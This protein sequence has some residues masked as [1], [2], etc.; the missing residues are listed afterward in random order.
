MTTEEDPF[1]KRD[2]ELKFEELLQSCLRQLKDVFI[3][4]KEL[5]KSEEEALGKEKLRLVEMSLGTCYMIYAKLDDKY[6]EIADNWFSKVIEGIISYHKKLKNLPYYNG[7][8]QL[9]AE[10]L[11]SC[12]HN[13]GLNSARCGEYELARK[14]YAKQIGILRNFYQLLGDKENYYEMSFE[15]GISIATSFLD[16]KKFKEAQDQIYSCKIIAEKIKKNKKNFEIIEEFKN[17]L[18]ED[19]T[20]YLQLLKIFDAHKTSEKFFNME[21]IEMESMFLKILKCS[22]EMDFLR[23]LKKIG[24]FEEK[25][26]LLLA[27]SILYKEGDVKELKIELV[28]YLIDILRENKSSKPEAKLVF[29][30][31]FKYWRSNRVGNEEKELE[32]LISCQCDYISILADLKISLEEIEKKVEELLESIKQS[33]DLQN[34]IFLL[35]NLEAIY[36]E[37]NV[38]N[39]R[40]DTVS[41]QIDVLKNTLKPN[42]IRIDFKSFMPFE[43]PATKKKSQADSIGK[44]KFEEEKLI[45]DMVDSSKKK[46]R[47]YIEE[48]KSSTG[49]NSFTNNQESFDQNSFKNKKSNFASS[50]SQVRPK[51]SLASACNR[52]EAQKENEATFPTNTKKKRRI[53]EFKNS[54]KKNFNRESVIY[55]SS[56]FAARKL[57]QKS[58]IDIS[59]D[60]NDLSIPEIY[61][62]LN[63]IELFTKFDISQQEITDK[64]FKDLIKIVLKIL[65]KTIDSII[66][67][68]RVFLI[69]ENFLSDNSIKILNNSIILSGLLE[70]LTEFDISWNSFS[71]SHDLISILEH[72]LLRNNSTLKNFGICGL[73]ARKEFLEDEKLQSRFSNLYMDIFAK[74]GQLC[75]LSLSKIGLT[76]FVKDFKEIKCKKLRM[77][78]LSYNNFNSGVIINCLLSRFLL[79]D[80]FELDL[81]YQTF[82]AEIAPEESIL[83]DLDIEAEKPE[84]KRL[85]LLSL[86]CISEEILKPLCLDSKSKLLVPLARAFLNIDIF[87]LSENDLNTSIKF[88]LSLIEG[89][90]FLEEE[91]GGK[92]IWGEVKLEQ[93]K[94]CKY[95][96]KNDIEKVFEFFKGKVG[97]FSFF[98]CEFDSELTE[99][100]DK[101]AE[102][103]SQIKL[104][105]L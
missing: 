57:T 2:L 96:H 35:R 84:Y 56:S 68:S 65:L 33:S 36:K 62:E 30:E 79:P 52:F 43:D 7:Y 95:V 15:V 4:S 71:L 104:K 73:E 44:R 21:F 70:N 77:L 41:V 91:L 69:N 64:I 9:E 10:Q 19:K 38:D 31:L 17:D 85:K 29:E 83:K 40:I 13:L 89:F 80:L 72:I 87:D 61:E 81:S 26:S 97:K 59:Q 50:S 75:E 23:F 60:L 101:Y 48:E 103:Y 28:N 25:S 39:K 76:R 82:E 88:L 12:Y 22:A 20:V 78:N 32:R 67:P 5:I 102:L 51:E 58:S 11:S 66:L 18:L 3:D 37:R 105:N 93:M 98:W 55:G 45:D 54:E 47:V 49:S 6:Y 63:L 14:F 34:A 92:I 74:L 42:R 27:K 100:I 53:G 86:R 8:S 90:E 46:K 99:T 1:L 94:N 16:E 24:S